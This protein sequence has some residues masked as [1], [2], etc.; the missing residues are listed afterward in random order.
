MYDN[1]CQRLSVVQADS[2]GPARRTPSILL[3]IVSGFFAH[4]LAHVFHETPHALRVVLI[5]SAKV[6]GSAKDSILASSDLGEA[7]RDSSRSSLEL[8]QWLQVGAAGFERTQDQNVHRFLQSRQ[9]YSYIGIDYIP[10]SESGCAACSTNTRSGTRLASTVRARVR[11][12]TG[13]LPALRSVFAHSLSV[14]P[15]V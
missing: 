1:A 15:V 6:F 7:K 12:Y 9:R 13:P 3:D 2:A 8:W 5:Q 10:N 11:A 14:V 4:F